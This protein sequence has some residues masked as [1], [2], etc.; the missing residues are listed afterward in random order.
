M[1][2]GKFLI[3][4]H[5]SLMK[6]KKVLFER[7]RTDCAPA[8]YLQIL[9][10]V[11]REVL[12]YGYLIYAVWQKGVS[13]ADFSLYFAAAMSFSGTL[14][15]LITHYEAFSRDAACIEDIREMMALPEE[16]MT[17][18]TL[19][20]EDFAGKPIIYLAQPLN[21]LPS[22]SP[23]RISPLSGSNNPQTNLIRVV[24]P[25]PFSPTNA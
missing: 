3:G 18:L 8:D 12:I 24:F 7:E 6:E 4:W 15:R 16:E 21:F 11:L 17:E 25:L 19:N 13:V 23:K 20:Y 5:K 14:N 10:A 2:M 9:L 22:T 1:G